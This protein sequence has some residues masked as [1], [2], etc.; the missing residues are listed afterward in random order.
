MDKNFIPTNKKLTWTM[1]IFFILSFSVFSFVK[2]KYGIDLFSALSYLVPLE[3][4]I[5]VAYFGKSGYEKYLDATSQIS[6]T[7]INNNGDNKE[8][9]Q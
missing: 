3:S 8:G 1:T 6:Q 4:I 2:V 5:I 7:V 9:E